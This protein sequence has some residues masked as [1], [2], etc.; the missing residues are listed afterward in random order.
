MP[1]DGYSLDGT[2]AFSHTFAATPTCPTVTAAVTSRFVRSRFGWYRAPVTVT[3][4]CT[5]GTS[6]LVGSCPGAITLSRSAITSGLTRTITTQDG[7]TATVTLPT[8]RIDRSPPT[9]RMTGVVPG[10]TYPRTRHL[11]CVAHDRYSGL[12]GHCVIGTRRVTHHRKAEIRFT[13]TAVD[14]AG[15]ATIVR[16]EYYL[17]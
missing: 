13:A 12:H 15:N 11:R 1:Q 14:R 4:T 10:Q 7:S 3:F 17:R 6:G 5:A 16:G 2:T 9:V 8:I